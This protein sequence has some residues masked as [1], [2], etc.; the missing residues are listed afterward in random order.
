MVL[1]QFWSQKSSK[2]FIDPCTI[3]TF[4]PFQSLGGLPTN[5]AEKVLTIPAGF[6]GNHPKACIGFQILIDSDRVWLI[7]IEYD[8]FS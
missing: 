7:L 2:N 4:G 5:L 1:T 3:H 8:G 6:A